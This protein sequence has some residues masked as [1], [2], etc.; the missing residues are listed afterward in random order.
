VSVA[1]ELVEHLLSG[2]V[3]QLQTFYDQ[4]LDKLPD[5]S[6][7]EVTEGVSNVLAVQPVSET[8][9]L[10]KTY[11]DPLIQRLMTKANHAT[12]DDGKLAVAGKITPFLSF[13]LTLTQL[14]LTAK[15]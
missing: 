5:I 3:L 2:Q 11:C 6:K 7:E 9:R 4:V 1:R 12:T 8:Y 15:L 10:L 13:S 14:Q